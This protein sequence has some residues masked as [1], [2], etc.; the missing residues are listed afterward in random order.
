[1]VQLCLSI[2]L[3]SV[4][5]KK[6]QIDNEYCY[7][8]IKYLFELD[9]HPKFYKYLDKFGDLNKKIN[10]LNFIIYIILYILFMIPL[11]KRS[12]FGGFAN[13]FLSLSSFII[14]IITCLINLAFTIYSVYIFIY[15][16]QLK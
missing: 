6:V 1:M 15:S 11:A 7:N 9:Y 13:I 16:C 12:F 14:S 10:N 8:Y 4:I 3:A 5:I 2:I